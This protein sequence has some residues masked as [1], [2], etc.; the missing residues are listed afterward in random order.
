MRQ[1]GKWVWLKKDMKN[2][3]G[4]E[5]ILPPDYIKVNMLEMICCYPF[6]MLP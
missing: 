5:N 4:D 6:A 3:Y 1:G 2:S